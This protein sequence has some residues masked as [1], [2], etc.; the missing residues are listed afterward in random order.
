MNSI[1]A[2]FSIWIL[3]ATLASGIRRFER[4]ADQNESEIIFGFENKSKDFEIVEIPVDA[5]EGEFKL[6]QIRV[7]TSESQKINPIEI[8]SRDLARQGYP[9]QGF[10]PGILN[11]GTDISSLS[12]AR[13]ELAPGSGLTGIPGQLVNVVFLLVN[14]GEA[15][16]FYV[17]VNEQN[18]GFGYDQVNILFFLFC[19]CF[20]FC[21]TDREYLQSK[22]SF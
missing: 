14:L 12:D 16:Y 4:Q 8:P 22:P 17:S 10:A 5:K 13:L 6:E 7:P 18:G 1:R 15:K 3:T 11:P 19:S 9:T 21:N 20:R 2:W